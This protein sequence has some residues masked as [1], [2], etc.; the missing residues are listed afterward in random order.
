MSCRPLHQQIICDLACGV[1]QAVALADLPGKMAV[2]RGPEPRTRRKPMAM[3]FPHS[4]TARRL[5]KWP[6]GQQ[7]F[8]VN[9]D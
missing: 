5:P 4:L 1:S 6:G 8:P 9:L 7:L 2:T 3:G